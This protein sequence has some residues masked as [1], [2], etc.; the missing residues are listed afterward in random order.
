MIFAVIGVGN[1]NFK[2][3]VYWKFLAEAPED[4]GP[5]P[6]YE[7]SHIGLFLGY[8]I[9]TFRMSLGDFDFEA[10][11][12]LTPWENYMFWFYWFLTVLVSCI[13]FLNFLI[14]EVSSSYEK[15]MET[16]D[17]QVF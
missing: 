11:M 4:W 6:M 14:A 5:P 1:P 10:S 3:N 16:V 13:I 9:S 17:A 8:I 12:R 7:Y 15:V 2:G